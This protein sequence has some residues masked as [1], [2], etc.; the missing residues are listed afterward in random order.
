[1][2]ILL[3]ATVVVTGCGSIPADVARGGDHAWE[4]WEQDKRP[5]LPDAEYDALP[6]EKQKFYMPQTKEAARLWEREQWTRR[7]HGK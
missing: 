2:F 7:V 5:T 1:M 4:V 6:A 3:T